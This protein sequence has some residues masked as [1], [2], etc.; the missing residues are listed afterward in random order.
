MEIKGYSRPLPAIK[1]YEQMPEL[2]IV[3]AWD[4]EI[5]LDLIIQSKEIIVDAK[6]GEAVLRGANVFAPGIIGMPHGE[7]LTFNTFFLMIINIK[8]T[9]EFHLYCLLLMIFILQV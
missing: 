9:N 5:V 3:N 6:C 7:I 1:T 2:M 4:D 8:F